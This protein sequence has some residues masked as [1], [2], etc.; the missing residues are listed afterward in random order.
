MLNFSSRL[1]KEMFKNLKEIIDP[2]TEV[3]Y[4]CGPEAMI[5]D[6]KDALVDAGMSESSIKYELFT[7]SVRTQR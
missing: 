6:C 5:I 3:A 7:A 1:D 4:I 2:K